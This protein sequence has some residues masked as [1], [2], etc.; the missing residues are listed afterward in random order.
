MFRVYELGAYVRS[1]PTR[2]QAASFIIDNT[3][4]GYLKFDDY[5]ILDES[6]F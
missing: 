6:D 3:L 2:D 5:E 1:F 4:V